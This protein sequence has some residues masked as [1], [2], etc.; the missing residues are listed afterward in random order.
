M[1]AKT[2]AEAA[3]VLKAGGTV[4]YPTETVYGIGASAFIPEAVERVFEIK[5][6]SREMPLSVAVASFEMMGLV[7]R[8]DE[9]E[10]L[11]LRRVLPGPVTVLVEKSPD[12]PDLI[13]AGSPLVGVRFPDHPMALELIGMTG[14]ITSTSANLSGRP[15]P[16]SVAE[17][18]PKIAGQ[19]DLV[20]NGGR[21]RFAS[22]STLVDLGKRK[23]IREGAGIDIAG[24]LLR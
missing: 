16:A 19:V 23:V 15:P 14:P 5:G 13:T 2:V 9:E 22:P 6:R 12:L 21:S 24:E 1:T 8:I 7:A 17:L 3:K 4:V 20:L 10:M 18:D 11:L